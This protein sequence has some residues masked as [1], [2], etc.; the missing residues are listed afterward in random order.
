MDGVAALVV[1]EGE[2][3]AFACETGG[4]GVEF[5]AVEGYFDLVLLARWEGSVNG[6]ADSDVEEACGAGGACSVEAEDSLVLHS[7]GAK[8]GVAGEGDV[9]GFTVD[10]DREAVIGIGCQCCIG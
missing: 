6:F 4:G 5:G 1:G 2:R 7:D 9:V 3:E 8:C 10:C